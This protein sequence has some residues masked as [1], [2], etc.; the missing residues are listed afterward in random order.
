MNKKIPTCLPTNSP[1]MIP[2]GN[3]FARSAS[4]MPSSEIPEFASANSG[5]IPYATQA[6][7][8]CTKRF[9]GGSMSSSCS[10][11]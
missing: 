9:S 2:S 6:C 7:H 10:S 1:T 8:R 11:M 3:G 5:T 4:A